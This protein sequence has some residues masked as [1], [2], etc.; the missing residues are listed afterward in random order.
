MTANSIRG[1]F[2]P[3]SKLNRFDLCTL[4]I[5]GIEIIT[6]KGKQAIVDFYK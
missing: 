2:S 4:E 5:K 1:F 6:P 3:D